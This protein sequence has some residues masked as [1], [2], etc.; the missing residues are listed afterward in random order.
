V[1][2]NARISGVSANIT[3]TIEGLRVRGADASDQALLLAF[4]D[5]CEMW[6]VDDWQGLHYFPPQAEWEKQYEQH[7]VSKCKKTHL[8]RG[9]LG[10]KP[11]PELPQNYFDL[12]CSVSVVEE[13]PLEQLLVIL[14]SL[15]RYVKPGGMIVNTHDWLLTDPGRYT[16]LIEAHETAGF[17]LGVKPGPPP[18]FDTN[19]LLLE[20]STTVMNYYQQCDGESRRFRGHWTSLLAKAVP[21]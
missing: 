15:R 5:T 20:N 6:G 3:G 9:L 7:V 14:K 11:P 10:E 19:E 17:S 4:Q 21:V 16:G 2:A 1:G 12:I 18:P 8:V 13:V